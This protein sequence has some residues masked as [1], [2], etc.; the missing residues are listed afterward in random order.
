MVGKLIAKR[1]VSK[2]TIKATLLKG[3][4]PL[5]TL[6]FKVLGENLFLID[7]KNERD[8][9]QVLEGRPWVFEGS[10]FSVVDYDGFTPSSR[11]SFD[12]AV[13]WM[14]MYYLPLVCMSS[15][16]GHQIGA[17]VGNVQEVDT[18]KDGMGWGEF[19]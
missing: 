11:I 16:K 15:T 4:K 18:D 1:M 13:F 17:T 7:F 9:T 12:R 14:W 10:L 3:W 19:L 5:G 8:K 2:E 6:S